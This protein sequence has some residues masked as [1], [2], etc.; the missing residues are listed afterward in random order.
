MHY[1]SQF[2]KISISICILVTLPGIVCAVT[3]QTDFTQEI[4]EDWQLQGNDSKW[5]IEEG[6]LR[7]EIES[8]KQWQTIFQLYQFIGISGPYYNLTIRVEDIGAAE[9][10]FGIALGKNFLNDDGEIEETGYYLFF[11]NDMQ[12][13]RDTNVFPSAGK[14]WE[15]DALTLLELH[16]DTGRFQLLG[17]GESRLDFRDEN[18]LHLDIIGFVLLEYVTDMKST[19]EGWVNKITISGLPV[20][21]KRKLTTI[22]G[23][24]KK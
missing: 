19:G 15:T 13:A 7:T 1:I 16:F 14:R 5:H 4:E 3:Y 17:D 11:T 9:L 2:L 6:Y 22:W 21:P 8:D 12:T 24:L 23:H 18:L 20:T 10:R